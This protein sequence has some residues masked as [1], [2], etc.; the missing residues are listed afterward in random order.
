MHVLLFFMYY[1]LIVGQMA[2][3]YFL[4]KEVNYSEYTCIKSVPVS[5]YGF[6]V[7][8]DSPV[9][10]KK[11]ARYHVEASISGSVNSCFGQDGQLSVV[12]CGVKFD[13]LNSALSSNGTKIER[14]QCNFLVFFLL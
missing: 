10:I 14:G 6:N 1:V 3:C 12:C 5:C 11:G 13:F 4:R 2:T 7:F 9:D 8:F